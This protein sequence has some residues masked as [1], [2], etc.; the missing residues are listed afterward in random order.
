VYVHETKLHSNFSH[1]SH[2]E[3]CQNLE[4]NASTPAGYPGLSCRKH[5]VLL[6][7]SFIA[8]FVKVSQFA[9]HFS[10]HC[11]KAALRHART[12]DGVRDTAEGRYWR[13]TRRNGGA[14]RSLFTHC[15]SARTESTGAT[16]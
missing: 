11:G 12:C 14:V 2:F 3:I 15:M 7:P 16:R 10:G 1:G 6:C 4:G 8:N 9:V 13:R 5:L